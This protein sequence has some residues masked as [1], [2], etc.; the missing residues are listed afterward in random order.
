MK[1]KKD[2]DKTK[3]DF[4]A[5]KYAVVVKVNKKDGSSVY[6]IVADYWWQSDNTA[7]IVDC[8]LY[9]EEPKTNDE[10]KK[11]YIGSEVLYF[12]SPEIESVEIISSIEE[13]NH[14]SHPEV[15]FETKTIKELY[16]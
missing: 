2:F 5:L 8:V 11:Y 10:L 9:S 12:P 15:G 14:G 4:E 3:F 7:D 13:E 16:A 6:A 1:T